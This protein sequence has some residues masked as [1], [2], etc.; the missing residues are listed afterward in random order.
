MNLNFGRNSTQTVSVEEEKRLKEG[1]SKKW[2]PTNVNKCLGLKTEERNT[3]CD[4]A[5]TR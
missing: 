1:I 4:F 5:G 2:P 3:K